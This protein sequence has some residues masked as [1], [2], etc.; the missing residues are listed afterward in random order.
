MARMTSIS[1]RLSEE[2]HAVS[3]T[4]DATSLDARRFNEAYGWNFP[5]ISKS[6]VIGSINALAE[7]VA[8]INDQD[9]ASISPAEES[10]I[11]ELMASLTS[12]RTHS[13]PNFA[14]NPTAGF[15][16]LLETLEFAR[17]EIETVFGLRKIP[18]TKLMPTPLLRRLRAQAE[19]LDQIDTEFG[20]ISDKVQ[21][22]NAASEAA[23][24]LPTTMEE[25]NSTKEKVSIISDEIEQSKASIMTSSKAA[26]EY[27]S[28]MREQHK[29]ADDL[30]RKSEEAFK[31]STTAGLAG[32]F[33]ERANQ[34]NKTLVIAI[35]ALAV[36]LAVAIWTNFDRAK[37]LKEILQNGNG[38]EQFYG[39]FIILVIGL[40]APIWFAWLATKQINQRFRLAEDYA[41]KA[42]VARAYEGYRREISTADPKFT[43]VLL[44]SALN[45][46]DEH[47][48]RFVEKENHGSPFSEIGLGGMFGFLKRKHPETPN[49]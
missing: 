39:E 3:K 31:L 2:L 27:L 49:N 15:S 33:H 36:A 21:A 37:L 6:Q 10:R 1:N 47:P 9:A 41:F 13:I 18:D 26:D 48:L 23:D 46:F 43:E 5:A 11:K 28:L 20:P 32:A 8:Q 22:I 30:V 16:S 44:K 25:L 4:L 40:G 45:R 29:L 12:I 19:R 24:L 7:Y 38:P 35:G 17:S 14:A 34:L 42:A